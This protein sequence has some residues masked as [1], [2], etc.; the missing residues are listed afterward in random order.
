M[1]LPQDSQERIRSIRASS[2]GEGDMLIRSFVAL[3][4]SLIVGVCTVFLWQMLRQNAEAQVARIAEAE[5]YATRSQFIRNFETQLSALY[6]ARNYWSAYGHLPQALWP[7]DAAVELDQLPGL[8]MLVWDDPA[9]GIRFTQTAGKRVFNYRP[10]DEEWSQLGKI[11][12]AAR[13]GTESSMLI[14]DTS[15]NEAATLTV[16]LPTSSGGDSGTLIA[17]MDARA[18]IGHLLLDKSPGYAIEVF[19]ED[20]LLFSRGVPDHDAPPSW[21]REGLVRPSLGNIWRI[22]HRPTVGLSRSLYSPSIDMVLLL[23]LVVAVLLGTLTF[24]NSRARSRAAAA[25]TAEREIALLNKNLES[26]VADRTRELAERN[27]D[28]EML[29]DSVTHDLRNPLNIIS[30]NV[31]MLEAVFADAI[32]P[33]GSEIIKRLS[34]SVQRMADIL[35]RLLGLSAISHTIFERNDIQVRAMVEDIASEL[36]SGESPPVELRI[37]NLPDAHADKT[38]LNMILV[39]LLGNAIKYTRD[40]ADRAV[41]VDYE[42]NEGVTT[43]YVRDNGVGF[44]Q[45]HAERLLIAFSR[46]GNSRS[47]EGVGLG[48]TIVSRAVKRHGGKIWAEGRPGEGAT[49]YFTLQPR[50]PNEDG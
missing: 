29:A 27:A 42:S 7:V 37:G 50:G 40:S 35:D 13:S 45:E 19:S 18:T 33:E 41:T 4:V 24:E 32:T 43:Y 21:T 25:E 39:N 47:V 30:V 26:E 14:S 3:V 44:A 2:S 10:D 16:F 6:G 28:L 31:E 17:I 36:V 9:R 8:T 49:F 48:L 5:S 38:L 23:G 15:D 22:V 46:L 34:P 11:V 20:K 12:A 1:F